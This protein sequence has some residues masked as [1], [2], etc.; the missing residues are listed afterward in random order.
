MALTGAAT[1]VTLATV[2]TIRV[3][4]P[5]TP[6]SQATG[7]GSPPAA[8]YRSGHDRAEDGELDQVPL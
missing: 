5:A 6:P 8:V 4:R 3:L 2:A 7:R 1:G